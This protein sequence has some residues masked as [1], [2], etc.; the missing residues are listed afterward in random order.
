MKIRNKRAC[1]KIAALCSCRCTVLGREYSELY[2][3]SKLHGV[4]SHNTVVLIMTDV[5]TS[6]FID[7]G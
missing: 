1:K 7:A 6:N 3:F 5:G 4:T 2:L